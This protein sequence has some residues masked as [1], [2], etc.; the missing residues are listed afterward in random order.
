M[1]HGLL[2]A[3]VW[4]D[5]I[6]R[7]LELAALLLWGGLGAFR[8]LVFRPAAGGAVETTNRFERRVIIGGLWLFLAAMAGEFIHQAMEMS[9]R[10][11]GELGPVIWPMMT[12]TH[13]GRIWLAQLALLGLLAWLVAGHGAGEANR[14]RFL[15]LVALL[16][17]TQSLSGHAANQGNWSPGVLVDW[18]HLLAVSFWAGGVVPLALLVPRLLKPLDA[19][20]ARL[21]LIQTLER[22]SAMAVPC[23]GILVATGLLSAAW[24]GVQSADLFGPDYARVLALKVALAAV[25]V[26]LG[27]VSRFII[28]PRLRRGPAEESRATR[29]LFGRVI[30]AEVGAAA[31]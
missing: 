24:R 7:G 25:A 27:G 21:F 31:A 2:S 12:R 9:R 22:F 15:I 20:T 6:F 4:I 3:H 19:R 29:R 8:A 16:A 5:A 17:L 30:A 28:L 11:F 13:F 26:G 14:R 1:T 23:V 18:L 10:P